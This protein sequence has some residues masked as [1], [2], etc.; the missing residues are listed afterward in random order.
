MKTYTKFLIFN[1]I[2]S[3]IYVTFIL[4]GL[5]IILNVLGELEFFKKIN[6]SSLF[7]I[8]L[9]LLNAPSFIFEMFPFIFLLSTQL[10]FVNIL[11]DNQ[12]QIFKY[13]GLKNIQII[14]IISATTFILSILIIFFFYNMSSNLKSYYL[15]LKIKYTADGKYLAVVTNNGLWIKD[16]VKENIYIVNASKINENYLIDA[17]IT[18]FDNEY[19]V[20]KNI[21]TNKINISEHEWLIYNP[22]IFQENTKEK[23][24][25][26]MMYSN[27]NHEKIKNLFSNLS[28][29]SLNELIKLKKNYDSLNYSSIDVS[30]QI[31]KLISYPVFLTMMT[32]LSSIIMFN[33][34][35]LKSNTLKLVSGLFVSVLIYYINNFF[36]V[37]GNTEKLS[38]LSSVWIP[39]SLLI[40]INVIY[41]RKINEK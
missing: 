36:N 9:A 39:V 1:F 11:E 29:L 14:K 33:S 30:V 17:F 16:V 8:Y 23:I 41:L 37:L 27:F 24:N 3:F 21:K 6:V 25:S 38:V 34:K 10:F 13:S 20:I 26:M 2:K 15:E 12:I 19:N 31:Q 32:L 28:S 4:L 5:I 18:Q 40:F 22:V 7:P 35:T